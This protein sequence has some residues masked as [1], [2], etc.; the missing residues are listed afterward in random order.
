MITRPL[1]LLLLLG[2]LASAG[3]AAADRTAAGMTV[4]DE[5]AGGAEIRGVIERVPSLSHVLGNSFS[6]QGEKS[7]A[8]QSDSEQNVGKLHSC[9]L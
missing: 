6:L 5:T 2:S 4:A 3:V 8:G 1:I 9:V 7:G